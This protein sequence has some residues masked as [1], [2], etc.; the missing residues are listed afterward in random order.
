MESQWKLAESQS[1]STTLK[2]L[3]ERLFLQPAAT[4]RPSRNHAELLQCVEVLSTS[5]LSRASKWEENTWASLLPIFHTM[6]R[7]T[8]FPSEPKTTVSGIP[9]QS[10]SANLAEL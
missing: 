3:R 7:A 8:L 10:K 6:P 2:S 4:P 9:S 5:I 1:S